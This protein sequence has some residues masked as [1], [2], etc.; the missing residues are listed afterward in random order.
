MTAWAPHLR[1]QLVELRHRAFGATLSST[2]AYL[3]WKYERNHAPRSGGIVTIVD[4]AT[5]S[6][7]VWA[8]LL[9]AAVESGAHPI[10]ITATAFSAEQVETLRRLDFEAIV[11]PDTRTHPTPGLF[12]RALSHA[13]PA[14]WSLGPKRVFDPDCWDVRMIDADAH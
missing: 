5:S 6:Y 12:L 9:T 13:E 2:R 8:D 4:W 14:E 7:G 11:Q 10:Q 1:A 3:E